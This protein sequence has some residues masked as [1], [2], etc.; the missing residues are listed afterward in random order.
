MPEGKSIDDLGGWK[1]VNRPGGDPVFSFNDEI[2][3]TLITVSEQSLPASFASDTDNR[4]AEL[5]KAYNATSRIKAGSLTA[6]IGTSA[7]GPQSVIL[8]KKELL[9]LIMSADRIPETAW[10]DYIQSLNS[11]GDNGPKF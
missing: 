6:Y 4:T 5:A 10:I 8:T 11:T 3:G 7:K 9:I 1:R 2:N